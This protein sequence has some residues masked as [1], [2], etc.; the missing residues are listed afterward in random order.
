MNKEMPFSSKVLREYF[1][2]KKKKLTHI[3][4]IH[5]MHVLS[6]N[7]QMRKYHTTD[8]WLYKR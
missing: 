6:R 2:E 5:F 8:H 4:E 3:P 7:P 1:T